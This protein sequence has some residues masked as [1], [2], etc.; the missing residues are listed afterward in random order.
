MIVLEDTTLYERLAAFFLLTVRLSAMFV[1]APF[2]SASALSVPVRVAF[3]MAF[4][5][6]AVASINVPPFDLFS[7]KGV[8]LVAHEI[9]IGAAIGL[10]VQLAFA[11]VSMAGEQIAAS[12]GIGFA[13]MIDPQTGSQSPVLTQFMS[14]MLLLIFLVVEGHHVLL[15][16]VVASYSVL[17]VGGDF[18]DPKMFLDITKA[19][20]LIFS[21][22]FIIGLPL[23][24]ALFFVNIIVGLLTRVAPQMN[25]FSIGFPLTIFVGFVLLTIAL[26]SLSKTIASFLHVV[27]QITRDVILA[28]T[29]K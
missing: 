20:G 28:G 12:M 7:I 21:A 8:L 15:R 27:S 18:L 3:A 24:A 29:G 14:I 16:H 1:A 9:I 2:F 17:P 25:I 4:A 19:A 10:T 6:V 26:P 11:A 23:I 5:L 22:A 13:S